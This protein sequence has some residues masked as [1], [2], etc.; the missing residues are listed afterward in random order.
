MTPETGSLQRVAMLV[1]RWPPDPG[2]V[3]GAAARL[4]RNLAPHMSLRVII[5][6]PRLPVGQVQI[7]QEGAI[8]LWRFGAATWLERQRGFAACLLAS[9]DFNL[10][11]AVYPSETGLPA[12]RVA[13]KRGVPCLLAARGNDLDRDADRPERGPALREALGLADAVVGVSHA[14][15]AK[16]HQLGASGQLVTIPNGVSPSRFRPFPRD[17]ALAARL[18]LPG[19]QAFPLIAFIGEARPKKGLDVMLTAFQR[20]RRYH[21]TACLWLMGGL[22]ED[23]QAT[24]EAFRAA[25][26]A[27]AQAVRIDPG[28]HPDDLPPLMAL[29]DL[30]WLPAH[31]DGLPNG[32][33]E[34]MACGLPSV[35]SAVGGIP[36]ALAHGPLADLLIP[37]GDAEALVTTTRALLQD[38]ARRQALAQAGRQ[39]VIEA[40]SPEAE[41]AAYRDLYSSLLAQTPRSA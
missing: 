38:P 4:S 37:P 17:P 2:G 7:G 21:P 15:T 23:G 35:A 18:G 3:A 14:L 30:A 31:Q 32:L 11:H 9:D 13:R 24:W 36:D 28:Y 10:I 20:L 26:P 25:H 33:L 22:R 1:P 39:R 8:A 40:F 27:D 34:A 6:D 19:E 12:T 41:C 5:P 16:A 29:A